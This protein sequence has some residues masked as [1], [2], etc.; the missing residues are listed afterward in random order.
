MQTFREESCP[1]S[2]ASLTVSTEES[3]ATLV[4]RLVSESPVP[5]V[6]D[7]DALNAFAGRGA[8]LADRRSEAVIT[9]HAGEFARAQAVEQLVAAVEEASVR[10]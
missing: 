9:P 10:P 4:R 2:R 6:I 7:A 8:Q 5:L 3:T 1:S